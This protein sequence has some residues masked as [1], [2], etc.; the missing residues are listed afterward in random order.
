MPLIELNS[1]KGHRVFYLF[2]NIRI[3]WNAYIGNKFLHDVAESIELGHKSL[4][5]FKRTNISVI[6]I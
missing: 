1:T 2:I 3:L 6:F 4:V 5:C